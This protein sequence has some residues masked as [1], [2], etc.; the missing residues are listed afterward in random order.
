MFICLDCGH[1]FEDGEFAEWDES[2]GWFDGHRY[3]KEMRGCPLCKGDYAEIKPC[4]LCGSYAHDPEEKY[5]EN[6]KADVKKRFTDFIDREFSDAERDLL[7][8]LYSDEY[9]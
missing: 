4:K 8:D 1:L 7:N 9:I 6:C 2:M 3:I 5:C